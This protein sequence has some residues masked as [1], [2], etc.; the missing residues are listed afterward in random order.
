MLVL[1]PQ[2]VGIFFGYK[3]LPFIKKIYVK[4]MEFTMDLHGTSKNAWSVISLQMFRLYETHGKQ[5]Q[6]SINVPQRAPRTL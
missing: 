1:T 2:D 3:I 5:T 6:K 4:E